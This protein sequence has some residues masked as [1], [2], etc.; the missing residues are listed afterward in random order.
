MEEKIPVC[1]Y[2]GQVHPCTQICRGVT[3]RRFLFLSGLAA[4]VPFLPNLPLP[5][6]PRFV[7]PSTRIAFNA[8]GILTTFDE[9][10]AVLKR[11]YVP[12]IQ[13][14]LARDLTFVERRGKR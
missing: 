3:R 4:A 2:C 7:A 5:P 13:D 1:D 10:N 6:V 14:Q 11:V 8:A 9:V 12:L